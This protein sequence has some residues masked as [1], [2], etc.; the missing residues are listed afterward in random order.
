MITSV[1][2]QPCSIASNRRRLSRYPPASLTVTVLVETRPF[3]FNLFEFCGMALSLLFFLLSQHLSFQ[4]AS[5][6]EQVQE[7]GH[8][9]LFEWGKVYTDGAISEHSFPKMDCQDFNQPICCSALEKVEP[10]FTQSSKKKSPNC[11][12][13][14]EYHPSPYEIN[15]LAKAEDLEQIKDMESRTSELISFIESV[16]EIEHAKNWLERVAERQPGIAIKENEVDKFYLSRFQVTK[17]CPN[18]PR[19]SWSEYIEP[20][21]IHARHPFGLQNCRSPHNSSTKLY[22]DRIVPPTS[23]TSV[24]YILLSPDHRRHHPLRKSQSPIRSK[25][26]L[27]DAGTSR[28]DSSL[29]WFVCAYQQVVSLTKAMFSPFFFL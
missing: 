26:F 14:K 19:I 2:L 18:E 12:V 27:L 8:K 9:N 7:G 1:D 13:R 29:K 20:L 21:S 3:E 10:K 28:F 6:T 17:S 22:W 24:D 11:H 23:I 16:E 25:T 5:L 4:K 15:H